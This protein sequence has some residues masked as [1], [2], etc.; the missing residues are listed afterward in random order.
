ML[1]NFTDLFAAF[2]RCG[3]LIA[4]ETPFG[5]V[6]FFCSGRARPNLRVLEGVAAKP[7]EAPA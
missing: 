5:Q 3:E 7:F 6:Q 4:A 2:I 1:L